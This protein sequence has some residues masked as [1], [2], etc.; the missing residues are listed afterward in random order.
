MKGW[1]AFGA[2]SK[3]L[4]MQSMC[5]V[6]CDFA[7]SGTMTLRNPKKPAELEG[8]AAG[9]RHFCTS[10]LEKLA[11]NKSLDK[12]SNHQKAVFNV[13]RFCGRAYENMEKFNPLSLVKHFGYV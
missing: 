5:P 12:G 11:Q 3:R 6:M 13:A 10:V 4:L 8:K 9:V 1:T 7:N 2:M